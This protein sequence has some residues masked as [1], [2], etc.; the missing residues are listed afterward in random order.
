VFRPGLR[1]T[2]LVD[3]MNRARSIADEHLAFA[4]ESEPGRDSQFRCEGD[5]FSIASHP[6]NRAVESA[7]YKHSTSPIENYRCRI[8]YVARKVFQAVLE[9]PPENRNRHMLSARSAARNQKRSTT[10]VESGIRNRMYVP[11]DSPAQCK[12]DVAVVAPIGRICCDANRHWPVRVDVRHKY[13]RS[14]RIDGYDM[15]IC[16]TDPNLKAAHH[17][18]RRSSQANDRFTAGNPGSGTNSCDIK[19]SHFA[20]LH[21]NGVLHRC[22]FAATAQ[23]LTVLKRVL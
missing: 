18:R 7:S 3:A 11:R 13:D 22:L 10:R 5:Y 8:C 20:T 17:I 6:I 14:F 21:R 2:D 16:T 23:S 15:R 19:F 4:V 12:I 1:L 9:C